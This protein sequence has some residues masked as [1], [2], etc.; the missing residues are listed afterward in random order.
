MK[1]FDKN[2]NL[3]AI[4]IKKSDIKDERKFLTSDEE[5]FQIGT[6]NLKKDTLIEDHIHLQRDREI[7]NTSEALFLIDGEME[8]KIYDNDRNF[9]EAINVNEGETIVLIS[10]GHGIKILSDCRF[11]E[12]KQGPYIEVEDKERF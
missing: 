2:N 12:V 5:E 11:V 1:I 3:L 10:G 7:T 9:I 4:L 6:F 8:V